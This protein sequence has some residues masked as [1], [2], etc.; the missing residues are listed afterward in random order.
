[1]TGASCNKPLELKKKNLNN[2]LAII[3]KFFLNLRTLQLG[4][5]E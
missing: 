3:S 4:I 2:T 5:G 1:M